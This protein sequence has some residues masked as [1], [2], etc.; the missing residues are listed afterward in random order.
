[1]R[2]VISVPLHCPC[3]PTRC[4]TTSRFIWSTGLFYSH[5]KED[6][7]EQIIDPTL[8]SEVIAYTGGA[9]TV[10]YTAQPCPNG[11]IAN[12]PLYQVIDKQVAGFGELTFKLT[13]TFKSTPR[14]Y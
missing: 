2:G 11:V 8:D 5:S 3:G 4:T 7:P 1:M 13:D 12:T 9:F 14:C 10:C 6:V